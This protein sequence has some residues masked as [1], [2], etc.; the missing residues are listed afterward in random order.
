MKHRDSILFAVVLMAVALGFISCASHPVKNTEQ[1][2][3]SVLKSEQESNPYPSHATAAQ[4]VPA[5]SLTAALPHYAA[6]AVAITTAV[7]STGENV[8]SLLLLILALLVLWAT[9]RQLRKNKK[10]AARRVL[11]APPAK[12]IPP[13]GN[14][15]HNGVLITSAG[16]A[17]L[18]HAKHNY[19]PNI[20]PVDHKDDII[21]AAFYYDQIHKMH[22][23]PNTTIKKVAGWAAYQCQISEEY[24]EE[25]YLTIRDYFAPLRDTA[26]VAHFVPRHRKHLELD[27]KVLARMRV[28]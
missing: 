21:I 20:V 10:P 8:L 11:I 22:F 25:V 18:L 2:S 26:H 4:A 5:S 12:V 7:S 3:V 9:L 28:R 24:L 16:P 27:V 17:H 1:P 14:L 15:I 13:T 19:H 23:A 6:K